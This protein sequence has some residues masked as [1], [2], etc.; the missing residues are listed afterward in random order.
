MK[1]KKRF[2]FVDAKTVMLVTVSLI[3]LAVGVFAFFTVWSEISD[4]STSPLSARQCE[5]VTDPTATQTITVRG[6]GSI[7]SVTEYLS[8][9]TTQTISSSDYTFNN[10]NDQI[11]ITV[12][13]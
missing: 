2:S 8:D 6:A 5:T 11:Q 1:D 4:P 9:G 13:G 12:T 3:I 10:E 7:N